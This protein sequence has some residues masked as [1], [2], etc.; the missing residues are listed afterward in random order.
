MSSGFNSFKRSFEVPT[1]R[2]RK[3]NAAF[4]ILNVPPQEVE[5]Y[6]RLVLLVAKRGSEDLNRMEIWLEPESERIE[7]L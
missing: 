6:G 1:R 3:N 4:S 5:L 2:T 7:E